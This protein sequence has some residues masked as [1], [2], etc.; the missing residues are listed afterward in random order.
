MNTTE[1]NKL[2]AE[3][4]GF[5]PEKKKLLT[6]DRYG[7]LFMKESTTYQIRPIRDDG[8]SNFHIDFQLEYHT[9][10]DWLMPVVKEVKLSAS[11]EDRYYEV[12]DRI[13]NALME[14]DINYTYQHVVDFI[15]NYNKTK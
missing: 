1:N 6:P 12:L 10:W 9:S 8:F 7:N 14:V 4:M 3:F 2:I 5:E 11:G 15:T 13:D